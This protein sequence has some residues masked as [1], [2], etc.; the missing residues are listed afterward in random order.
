MG[1]AS[2]WFLYGVAHL[3]EADFGNYR[4]PLLAFFF[5]V[6][7]LSC[8]YVR[9]FLAVRA[10][11]ILVLMTA[12]LLLDAAF[13]EEPGRR[14]F[15]VAFVYLCIVAALYLGT[16]PYRARDFFD[17]LF[18]R[19]SRTFAVGSILAA[20]GLLLSSIAFSY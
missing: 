7:V 13:M 12:K 2:A 10:A 3:G 17:W 18:A 6:A 5:A 11:S 15:M 14:L 4:K 16:L 20:Y 9:D 1:V 8:F 19:G